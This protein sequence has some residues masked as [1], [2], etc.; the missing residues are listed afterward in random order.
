MDFIHNRR[1][2]SYGLENGK[3]GFFPA[4]F[5]PNKNHRMLLTSFSIF[6]DHN[7]EKRLDLVFAAPF[8]HC[9]DNIKKDIKK[10]GLIT[11][12]HFIIAEN[13]N[14]LAALWK[15]CLFSIFPSLEESCSLFLLES[16]NYRKPILCSSIPSFRQFAGDAALYFDPRS[17]ENIVN[18]LEKITGDENLRTELVKRGQRRLEQL[19]VS[20]IRKNRKSSNT[21]LAGGLNAKLGLISGIYKDRWTG[22]EILIFFDSGPR[23]R[24]IEFHLDAPSHLPMPN[25]SIS[26]RLNNQ[27][28]QEQA[29]ARGS[30]VLIR[31]VLPRGSGYLT[32]W[33]SPV[34][35][36]SAI[37][38]GVGDNRFIGCLC[39]G[40]WIVSA[41]HERIP[42]FIPDNSLA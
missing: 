20:G 29:L 28:I 15:G 19:D 25:L 13:K 42:L 41:D 6:A 11:R 33:I 23:K 40:C 3:Y 35:R 31:Q 39:H 16:M 10:M 4:C 7:P 1:L 36:P 38:N 12:V 27:R 21:F 9:L 22:P 5:W 17:P 24:Y 37:T 14:R 30:D 8:R 2:K 34:F 26:W 18:S 32:V